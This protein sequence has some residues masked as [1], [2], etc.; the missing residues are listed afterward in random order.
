[1]VLLGGI[2][3]NI[4]E[5]PNVFMPKYFKLHHPDGTI[6]DLINQLSHPQDLFRQENDTSDSV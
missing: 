6:E 1:M 3:V 2:Q 4:A 5:Q